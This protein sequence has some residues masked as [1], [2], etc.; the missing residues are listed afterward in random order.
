[1]TKKYQSNFN[2]AVKAAYKLGKMDGL[3]YSEQKTKSLINCMRNVN[4]HLYELTN[5]LDDELPV[6]GVNIGIEDVR[7]IIT[8][9]LN[10][11]KNRQLA[12]KLKRIVLDKEG[13]DLHVNMEKL[14]R[15]LQEAA[16]NL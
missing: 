2:Q 1:M 9:L 10:G 5:I 4:K 16:S 12:G 13:E 11:E 14:K 7:K 15:Q 6:T 8:S 3:E